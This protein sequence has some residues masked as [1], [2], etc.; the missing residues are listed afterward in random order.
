MK[1]SQIYL[2]LWKCSPNSK[3]EGLTYLWST[4]VP[5][6]DV[7]GSPL[8]QISLHS[9][10]LGQWSTTTLNMGMLVAV[11]AQL[12]GHRLDYTSVEPPLDTSIWHVG[13]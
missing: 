4:K 13:W 10:G 3:N 1:P 8:L 2:Q 5:F 11:V 12:E 7:E 6:G 9:M